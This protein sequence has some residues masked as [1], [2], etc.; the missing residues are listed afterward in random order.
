M[1]MVQA[2]HTVD[3]VPWEEPVIWGFLSPALEKKSVSQILLF[4]AVRKMSL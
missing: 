4:G 1:L 3:G 2:S